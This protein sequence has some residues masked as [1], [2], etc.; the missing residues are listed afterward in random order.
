V[1]GS[2]DEVRSGDFGDAVG[3]SSDGSWALIGGYGDDGSLGA[4][5]EFAAP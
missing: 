3:I 2:V 5:W 1:A 4:V